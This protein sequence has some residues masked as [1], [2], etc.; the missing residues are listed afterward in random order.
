MKLKVL[1]SIILI[2]SLVITP[3]YLFGVSNYQHVAKADSLTL[4]DKDKNKKSDALDYRLQGAKDVDEFDVIVQ[5]DSKETDVY[6]KLAEKIAKHAYKYQYQTFPAFSAKLNKKQIEELATLP[7]ITRIEY[8]EKV[9]AT[10]STATN[11]FG[12]AKASTDFSVTGDR[13]GS[14]SYSK[15]DVVIA[16]IDT[17]IDINHV[18][19]NNGKVIAWKDYVLGQTTPYD[20]NG[21]GTHVSS[22]AAGEGEANS[23]YKGVATGTAL[24]GLKVL[25]SNGSG[26]MDNVTAAIDWAVLNKDLYGI[27]ILNL[28]LGTSG[29]SDGTD[30]TSV[31]VNNAVNSGLVV[32]VAA[33]N[34]GPATYTIGS[35][36]AAENAITVAAMSDIGE[37]GFSLAY[38]SSRGYTADGRI[39]P[40]IAAPGYYITAAQAN[41]GTGYI[42][43]SG[44]SMA[45]PF[46]SGTVALMLDANPNLLPLDVKNILYG[47][48]QDWGPAGK[49]IDY[50]YGKLDGYEAVRQAG[51]FTGTNIVLPNHYYVSD[52]VANKA[53]K[54]YTLNVTST[55][56]PIAITM[57]IT[58]WK[59]GTPNL[60]LYLYNPNGIL[61][62]SSA[63][64]TR[65]ETIAYTP[66]VTGTYTIKVVSKTGSGYYF[67]DVSAK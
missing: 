19:L 24:V 35:P 2:L 8:N 67:F 29:S 11:Y 50:G 5:Y 18:D 22:I 36:G 59:T 31:A 64:T 53:T 54:S 27:K 21:H 38:F 16:V 3:S 9:Y 63:G 23:L 28:S 62:A 45:T 61:V 48:A 57:V 7:F 25:D 60:N 32:V 55:S 10:L 15:N 4:I 37:K 52:Y 51:N 47:T 14:V 42:T 26:T 39:K 44:T 41:T 43:Y 66:T 65:Q 46:V 34:A 17:G 58:S 49:D 30:A 1:I 6:N 20:D 12:T 40:D 13:D 56:Y 33:G